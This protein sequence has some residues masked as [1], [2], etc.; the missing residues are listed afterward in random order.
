MVMNA[1][2]IIKPINL[3]PRI[4]GSFK[5]SMMKVMMWISIP[6]WLL[7]SVLVA[8]IADNLILGIV[9]FLALL[10]GVAATIVLFSGGKYKPEKSFFFWRLSKGKMSKLYKYFTIG[11]VIIIVLLSLYEFKVQNVFYLIAVLIALYAAQ[12]SFA[13]HEDVDFVANMEVSDLLGMEVDEKIQASYLNFD[14]SN[15]PSDGSNIMLL[16]DKKLLFAFYDGSKW[17]LM[18][19]FLKDIAKIGR[20][21]TEGVV[22]LTSSSSCLYVEFIDN[23]NL[24]LHM[25]LYDK[26]TSN[27]DLF[28]K[29]FLTTLDAVVLGKT[30]EKIASRRRVSV[31][32]EPKPSV[33]DNNEG[34][35]VR[36]I[37]ISDTILGNLR[38]ATPI[39]SGRTLEF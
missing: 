4:M 39:E 13:V 15:K 38:D 10:M 18:N 9:A 33:S 14:T 29:K 28:F 5:G 23:T 27:P 21:N 31:N 32:N 19:K 1:I 37:D 25:N 11:G 3:F 6:V 12:K 17:S 2:S 7:A 30:D 20:I 36:T 35:D 16:T 24:I 8:F 34:I 22:N 26:L